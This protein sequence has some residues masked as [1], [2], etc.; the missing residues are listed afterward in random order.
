MKIPDPDALAAQVQLVAASV[1]LLASLLL[2]A[3]S[4]RRSRRARGLRKR[5]GIPE[6]QVVYSDLDRPAHSLFSSRHGIAG[7]PDYIV[8]DGRQ[9]IPVEVKSSQARQPHRSHMLK[10][11]A[12]CLLVEENYHTRVPYGI[13][14]YQGRQHQVHFDDSLRRD[15]H[16]HLEGM[17]ARL[18]DGSARRNHEQKG[19]C[20]H[21]RF[22]EVCGQA[23][24]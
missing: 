5:F 18:R 13:L 10:L 19:R 9:M 2:A 8:R 3:A 6:G 1:L 17:R 7:K 4:W 21:C 12:Y 22:R 24:T 20:A 14:V 11:A 15:L 16:Q 23:L